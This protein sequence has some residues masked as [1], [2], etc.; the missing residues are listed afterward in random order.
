MSCR[1][2]LDEL[3]ELVHVRYRWCLGT[4]R[5]IQLHNP[6]S[7]VRARVARSQLSGGSLCDLV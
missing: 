5:M 6:I 2:Q 7:G 4:T 3:Q 1:S